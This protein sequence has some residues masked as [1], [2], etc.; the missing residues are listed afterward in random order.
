MVKRGKKNSILWVVGIIALLL[1]VLWLYRISNKTEVDPARDRL[2]KMNDSL[3]HQLEVNSG[4]IDGLYI[5]ID[6]LDILSDT[7][8]NKQTIV[9]EYHRNEVY[10]ILSSDAKSNNRRLSETFRLSDSLLKSGFYTRT[11]K[12]PSTTD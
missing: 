7:L 8:L 10:N 3:F 4:K 11:I 6:S 1:G 5:K 2:E 9:N 12:F